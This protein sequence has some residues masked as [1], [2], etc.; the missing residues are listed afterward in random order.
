LSLL[1]LSLLTACG[2]KPAYKQQSFVFGTLVEVSVYGAD[3]AKAKAAVD[4]VLADFDAMHRQLH[5]WEPSDL[6]RLNSAIA[7]GK[8]GETRRIQA[9]PGLVPL[10]ADAARYSAQGDFL[11]NPAIGNLIR[12]W[13]FHSDTFEPKLP[14][15][16]E[17]ERLVKAKPSLADLKFEGDTVVGANPAVRVDLGGY[18]KG[19]AL[20][21]A[22]AYLHGQ[23]VDNALVN[24]GGN[25][26]ALGQH[27]KRPWKIGIQHPRRPGALAM[28]ELRD[29]EAIGT[30]G[31]YQRYFEVSGRRYC[32]LIDP[33][34]GWPAQGTQAVTVLTR[35]AQAGVRSD[36]SSKPLFIAGP[37]S[38]RAMA[39]RMGIGEALIVDAQGRIQVTQALAGRL[40]WAQGTP[41]PAIVP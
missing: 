22:A 20:D 31:D 17:V 10:L 23:G 35:G 25:I 3:E 21:R 28:L 12:L 36:V 6:E 5:A 13:G 1:T 9:A 29:G 30:S 19:L 40:E 14:P 24:I 38:W 34:T 39:T 32:H 18:A 27:G 2:D 37:D 41:R 26:I 4:H 8:P 16:A 15:A 11:F 7:E 33:R